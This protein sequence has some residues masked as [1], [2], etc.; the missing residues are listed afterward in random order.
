MKKDVLL[1]EH[2][3]QDIRFS[4]KENFK[5]LVFYGSLL[6]ILVSLLIASF[7]LA[8]ALFLYYLLCYI[9]ALGT[10]IYKIVKH[11]SH[12]AALNR[13]AQDAD[14]LVTDKLVNAE[15]IDRY[16]GNNPIGRYRLHF[17]QYGQYLIPRKN[18]VW[19]ETFSMSDQGVYNYSIPGDEFYLILS[20]PHS[21]RILFAYNKKMFDLEKSAN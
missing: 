11:A 13:S 10:L 4:K 9:V 8:P 12:L 2:I 16:R 18:Y 7:A 3:R 6:A 5:F 21:G 15:S 1:F 17:A 19:S 20:K 14:C